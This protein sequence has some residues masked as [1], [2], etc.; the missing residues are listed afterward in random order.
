MIVKRFNPVSVAKLSGIM[1]A[2]MGLILRTL[3]AAVSLIGLGM[4]ILS[5]SGIF[6]GGAIIFLPLVY[7]IMGLVMGFIGA[8]IYNWVASKVGGIEIE[9][10]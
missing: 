5:P 3:F 4:G 2:I 8:I 1:Y 6:G 7:G 9:I 10:E